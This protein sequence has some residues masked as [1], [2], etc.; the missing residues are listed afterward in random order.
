MS[1]LESNF[2]GLVHSLVPLGELSAPSKAQILTRAEILR[3]QPEEFVFK[4]GER[5]PYCF[6]LLEGQLELIC[7]GETIHR[8]IGGAPD[9]V[10][11]LAQLQPRKMSARAQSE[12]AVLR[13][14][15]DL[16]DKLAAA[17]RSDNYCDVQVSEIDTE[18]DGDW[19]TR[20][21]Q[22]K[23]FSHL[24]ASNIHRI[25]SLLETV[26][27]K[28]G[29]VIVNQGEPGDYYYVITQGRCEVT[30]SSGANAPGYRLALFGPGDA[31]GEEALVAGSTRNASV[32][33]LTDGQLVR[34]PKEG[35]VEL[36]QRPLLNGVTLEEGRNIV[37]VRNALWLDVRFPEEHEADGLDRSVNYPLNTLRMHSGKLESDRSY[38]VYCNDGI[39]S[40][41]AAFLLAERG[42]DVHCLNGGLAQ[43]T[44]LVRSDDLDMTLHDDA[45]FV[46]EIRSTTA[47]IP[48]SHLSDSERKGDASVEAAALEVELGI[49]EVRIAD[50]TAR[51]DADRSDGNDTGRPA[52]AETEIEANRKAEEKEHREVD[53]AEAEK[54]RA[55]AARAAVDEARAEAEAKA[56]QQI[57]AER[58]RI[59]AEIETA[60]I[61]AERKADERLQEEKKRL[62]ADAETARRELQEAKRLKAEIVQEKAR[63]EESVRRE[64]E[65]Q[66]EKVA[67]VQAEMERRL[68]DE[69]RK[70]K[71]S[72]AWQAEELERLKI[73]KAEAEVRLRE[74]QMRVETQAEE[75]R[76]RLAQ[77][78]DYQERLQEVELASAREA[79]MREEQQLALERRLQ[80]EL[81]QNV[82]FERQKLEEELT[83]NATELERARHERDA[84]EAARVAAADEA[85]K[86]VAE[87][88]DAHARKRLQEET[89]MRVE[90]ERLQAE[91]K[92][93]RLAL[94]LAQR[95]N[96]V[97][98]DAQKQIEQEIEVLKASQI[99]DSTKVDTDLNALEDQARQAADHVAKVER[100][101]ADAQAASVASIGDL[102]VHKV[103]QQ[104]VREDLRGELDDWLKE[105][106]E[107][108]NSDAQRGILANQKAHIE[109]IR[110]RAHAARDAAKA[111]DHDLVN[112]LAAKLRQRDE[113][114]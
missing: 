39:R 11:A 95:E 99:G 64:R 52:A 9:A 112:E 18:N 100:T 104:Q 49:N 110:K 34:L 103:R 73:Q 60:R 56:A 114:Q 86:I 50:A 111:H 38:I 82:R 57:E 27:A 88:K 102:A 54:V 69:E 45:D 47:P 23:L 113:D 44:D 105:Q 28:Q 70:L 33:M 63:A 53:F 58:E 29:E 75:S 97:A 78:R 74:E 84:A 48:T 40:A 108:E 46:G 26:E 15:R 85:Q 62:E 3:Y 68:K 36:I 106:S 89:D 77:A 22:S 83:R 91:S 35:F 25:F 93:L 19:M 90:R 71:E 55:A 109:R 80:K 14:N 4:Q 20:M 5:D 8:L 10:H 12:V 41:V 98:L 2:E 7:D 31:F 32:R 87:F 37:A 13:L 101:R 21:L 94:E 30:R 59:A 61:A 1:A 51:T 66:R 72:Y 96:H 67:R 92:R 6:Y 107:I 79:E 42:F 16:L 43:Y 17:D 76:V 24:P 81:K 65:A